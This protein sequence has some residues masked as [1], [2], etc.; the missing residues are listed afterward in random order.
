[1]RK[2]SLL[3]C[4][5]IVVAF[6]VCALFSCDDSEDD[7]SLKTQH[8]IELEIDGNASYAESVTYEVEEVDGLTQKLEKSYS[9]IQLPYKESFDYIGEF[10]GNFAVFYNDISA[11]YNLKVYVDK[12]LIDESQ[13]VE[14]LENNSK[15]YSYMTKVSFCSGM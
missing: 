1:M 4:K 10:R 12:H 3:L 11:G 2:Q 5:A 13:K 7:H 15:N 14:V 9:S 8:L 6:V